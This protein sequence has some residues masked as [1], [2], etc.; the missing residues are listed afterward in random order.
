MAQNRYCYYQKQNP[1]T[2]KVL[3]NLGFSESK[4]KEFIANNLFPELA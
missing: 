2:P 1:H 4:A 3:V